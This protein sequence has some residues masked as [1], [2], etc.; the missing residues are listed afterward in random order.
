MEELDVEDVAETGV[1]EPGEVVVGEEVL[2]ALDVEPD[3]VGV[4]VG[5]FNNGGRRVGPWAI[6]PEVPQH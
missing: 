6:H 3:A 5:D 2:G 4:D 1:S